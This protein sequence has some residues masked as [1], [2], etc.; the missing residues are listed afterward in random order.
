LSHAWI[1]S[2]GY[3]APAQEVRLL[4][5]DTASVS[6][7]IP[8]ADTIARRICSP[9]DPSTEY[10]TVVGLIRDGSSGRPA[11]GTDVKV[12]W[13]VLAQTDTGL[14]PRAVEQVVRAS[15][16]GTYVLCGLPLG[17]PITI[18]AA[19]A[20]SANIVFPRKTD[21]RLLFARDRDPN[22]EYTR[23]FQTAHRTWKVDLLLTGAPPSRSSQMV[24]PF[25]SGYVTDHTTGLPVEGV[26]LSLN[27]TDSTVTR[28]DGT[29]DIVDVEWLPGANVVATRRLGYAPWGQEIWLEE[30]AGSLELSVQ[31]LPQAID[32]GMEVIDATPGQRRWDCRS[33]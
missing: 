4:P 7:T 31:L 3:S 33:R 15:E 8:H 10:A 27:G 32:T 22:K 29:F 17:H 25:I 20:R 28:A 5:Y 19:G 1:D 6:F 30:G 11:R 2:V 26:V 14:V 13:Q 12:S 24:R 21:G 23:S 16:S 9:T 18:E